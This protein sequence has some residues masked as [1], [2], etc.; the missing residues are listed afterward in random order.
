M[1]TYFH[2]RADRPDSR[3]LC[4][5]RPGVCTDLANGTCVQLKLRPAPI[6][7]TE[8]RRT[9]SPFKD[10]IGALADGWSA[11]IAGAFLTH[12][13]LRLAFPKSYLCRPAVVQAD[14][15]GASKAGARELN[16]PSAVTP[17]TARV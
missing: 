13:L 8:T 16:A 9:Q 17:G 6:R 1:P 2:S 11:I 14:P 5:D 7:I 12:E 10:G 15:G 4:Y 3:S